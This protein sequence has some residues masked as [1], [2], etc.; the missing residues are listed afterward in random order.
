MRNLE[1]Y[2]RIKLKLLIQSVLFKNTN[3]FDPPFYLLVLLEKNNYKLVHF[4]QSKLLAC[5]AWI[6]QA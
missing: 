3:I 5:E 1:N 6:G 4:A 2:C